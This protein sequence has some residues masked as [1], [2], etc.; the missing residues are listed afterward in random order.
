VHIDEISLYPEAITIGDTLLIVADVRGSDL[1]FSWITTD[2]RF[3]SLNGRWVRWKAPDSPG[4]AT[5]TILAFNEEESRSA[6]IPITVS[7]YAAR[8]APT[9][10]GAAYCGLE[11]HDV[12]G[13]GSHYESWAQSAHATIYGQTDT[14]SR[15]AGACAACHTVGY[16]DIDDRGWARHNGGFD[17]AP[18]AQLQGVQC[19]SCHGPLADE[20]GTILDDH[21]ERARGDFLIESCRGC[22]SDTEIEFASDIHAP[23]AQVLAGEGGYSYGLTIPSTP[24]VSTVARDCVSCH[25]PAETVQGSHSFAADPASCEACHAEAGGGDFDWSEGMAEV[26]D[27]LRELK[28]ELALATE[29]DKRYYAY[30]WAL[31][32]ATLVERDGSSGAHNYEY[33]RELLQ[34]SLDHFEPSG[35]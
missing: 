13:H 22:H 33:A 3:L 6:S 10:T 5:V 1:E 29:D 17:D 26:S 16:G 19:E 35:R 18:I 11:C 28:V 14:E 21:G 15:T 34:L 2:G 30:E 24:H 9:Y 23:Q 12:A 4:V 25:Y 31:R 8:H 20:E 32:N 27:L 7:P